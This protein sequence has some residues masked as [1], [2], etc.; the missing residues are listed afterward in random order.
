MHQVSL[1]LTASIGRVIFVGR[2]EELDELQAWW[3]RPAAGPAF[4]WGRRR[5]GKTALLQ[6]FAERTGAPVVFHTGTGQGQRAEVA[7]VCRRIAAAFPDGHRDMAAEPHR[8]WRDVLDYLAQAARASPMLLVLDEFPELAGASPALAATLR[9]FLDEACGRTQLRIVLS[10]APARRAAEVSQVMVPLHSKLGLTLQVRPLPPHQAALMLP[11]LDPAER[12]R[13]YAVCGGTP[14]YLSWWNQDAA[15]AENLY[16][17][18]GQPGAPLL[19]EGQLAMAADVGEGEHTMEV[20]AAIA[21]GRTRHSE[22]KA[23]IG[24]EPSRTLDRLVGLRVIERL[25]PVT[26]QGT[27]SRRRL[28]RIADHYLEFYLGTLTR[29]RTEIERGLGTSAVRP[30]AAWLDARMGPVYEEAF[31]Q[32]LRRLA[33]AGALGE[34]VE[35]IGS[36]WSED[37]QQEI[38]AVALAQ[39]G[40]AYVP[41]LIGES[42][43]AAAVDARKS[44]FGLVRKSAALVGSSERLRYAVCA[45][46]RVEHTESDVLAVTAKDIFG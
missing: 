26:E 40:S 45:R 1:T 35:A 32:H 12:A 31:R 29:F 20:L 9:A 8:S 24:A 43:W 22:I 18:A 19:T 33:A 42:R 46:E 38:G 23:L 15:L 4:V 16:K 39:D 36:W 17:L 44:K 25:V 11:G 14:L 6:R 2:A 27:R 30:M 3:E 7:A 10:G 34:G 28:Y 13:A 41:V 5:V 21:A 37:G